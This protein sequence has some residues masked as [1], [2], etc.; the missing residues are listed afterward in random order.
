MKKTNET[1][2]LNKLTQ[3]RGISLS[4]VATVQSALEIQI[5][6]IAIK[7][8]SGVTIKKGFIENGIKYE[9]NSPVNGITGGIIGWDETVASSEGKDNSFTLGI[10]MPKYNDANWYIDENGKVCLQIGTKK[11]TSGTV[12]TA[13]AIYRG[14]TINDKTEGVTYTDKDGNA[15]ALTDKPEDG[16]IVIYGDYEYRYNMVWNEQWVTIA[17]INMTGMLNFENG[18]GVRVV[19]DTKSEYS[20]LCGVIL[21]ENVTN[22]TGTF[23]MC[24]SLVEAPKI[25]SGV[26]Y[27][28]GAF[29]GCISLVEI[30]EIPDSVI[31]M[32]TTFYECTSLVE[33]PE[34]PG[35]VI[36]L[37][38]TFANCTSLVE[39]PKISHGVKS[40][41]NTFSGCTNLVN[42]SEIPGSV[43]NLTPTFENCTSLVNAPR[44]LEWNPVVSVNTKKSD[45]LTRAMIVIPENGVTMNSTFYGCTS[46][47]YVPKLP[48][49]ILY[50]TDTFRGCTSLEEAPEIPINVKQVWA[51]FYD[52]TSLTG[53]VVINANPDMYQNCFYNT[54][55]PI[56]LIKSGNA[57]DEMIA[58]LA[59]TANN[60]N[61]TY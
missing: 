37:E 32:T 8:L 5:G 57:T 54:I 52:C 6:N 10:E 27:M 38:A 16:D 25:P 29:Y 55:L 22:M 28:L 1:N 21:G 56:K 47:K 13:K 19:D 11:Y 48:N 23:Y 41:G 50:M 7:K 40:M 42:V 17:E 31:N 53:D 58:G 12:E 9:L 24:E 18:W 49:S 34:I 61:V 2:D 45:N 15:K 46:L 59:A 33:A 51:M 35:S 14:L 44:I 30:S 39:V 4:D 43:N 26:T 3:K 60:G 20:E 36:S